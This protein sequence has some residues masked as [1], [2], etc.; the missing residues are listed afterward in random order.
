[1]LEINQLCIIL[2]QQVC[3]PIVS[4]LQTIPLK[5]ETYGIS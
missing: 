4:E 2:P 5:P 1:M 3:I